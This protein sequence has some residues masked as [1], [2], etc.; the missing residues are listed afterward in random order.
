MV[1]KGPSHTTETCITE[2][3]LDVK[4]GKDL[5][6]VHFGIVSSEASSTGTATDH[7]IQPQ[8]DSNPA[9]TSTS[10]QVASICD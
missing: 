2:V 10:Q 6:P 7:E 4:G 3:A 9:L 1:V 5:S 8:R